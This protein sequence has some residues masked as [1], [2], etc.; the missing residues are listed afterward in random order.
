[1]STLILTSVLFEGEWSA[2]RS[3]DFTVRK[4][5]VIHWICGFLQWKEIFKKLRLSTNLEMLLQSAMRAGKTA[6]S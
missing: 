5:N 6:E 4:N 2:S 3:A 1:M